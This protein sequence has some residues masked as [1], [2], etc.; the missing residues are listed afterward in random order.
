[1]RK[2]D[3]I[4]LRMVKQ[5][6]E[7]CAKCR[8]L[9]KEEMLCSGVRPW[10]NDDEVEYYGIL[11]LVHEPCFK[12][13]NIMHG[14]SFN[15]RLKEAGLPGIYVGRYIANIPKIELNWLEFSLNN[16]KL[17]LDITRTLVKENYSPL[18]VY[19]PVFYGEYEGYWDNVASK[20]LSCDILI[21]D[22]L[23]Y[24]KGADFKKEA[25][26]SGLAQRIT[27]GLPTIVT[28]SLKPNPT[29]DLEKQIYEEIGTWPELFTKELV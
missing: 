26:L 19:T 22:S 10:I 6:D 1:M 3:E 29:T 27:M 21:V 17:L 18:Y 4:S 9:P 23:D 16:S 25:L 8:K 2:L 7:L 28:T 13:L 15:I 5:A 14:K 24:S 11:K 20:L 12:L